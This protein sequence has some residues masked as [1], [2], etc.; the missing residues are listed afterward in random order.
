M[1]RLGALAA[2]SLLCSIAATAETLPELFHKA[3]AQVKG[4]A[5]QDALKTL[6]RLDAESAKPGN[7]FARPQLAGPLAF[8]RGV[9]EANLGNADGARAAFAAFLAIEP[10]ASMDPSMYSKKAIA[11]FDAARKDL[12]SRTAAVPTASVDG[13]PALFQAYRDFRMPANSGESV[14]SGWAEGPVRWIITAD[15]LRRW[16]DLAIGS[17]WQEFVDRFWEARNP[18]PGNADNVFKTTFDRRVAFADANFI[19]AEARRGSLTD[20][21]MVFVLLGPPA[22]VGRR[23]IRAGEDANE[24]AGLSRVGSRGTSFAQLEAGGPSW[25]EVWHYRTEQVDVEF[26]TRSGYGTGVLQREPTTLAALDGA[27]SQRSRN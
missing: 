8:Y 23:P 16:H 1:R 2:V 9:C 11:A 7:E 27:R 21:G 15:E 19:Q 6:E 10:G 20:R 17:D 3:K 18:R 14:N 25:R 22:Y 5:W 26:I 4:E 13:T 12:A 24:A